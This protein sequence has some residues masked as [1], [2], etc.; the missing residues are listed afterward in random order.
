MLDKTRSS[1]SR[2]IKSMTDPIRM[3]TEHYVHGIFCEDVRLEVGHTT[4]IIGVYPANLAT[5]IGCPFAIPRFTAVLWV[6]YP[7]A[8]EPPS[9]S[10]KLEVPGAAPITVMENANIPNADLP[11]D[12]NRV[13]GMI[14]LRAANLVV[15]DLG[16]IRLRVQAWG[17]EWTA[18]S[19]RIVAAADGAHQ[20]TSAIATPPSVQSPPAAPETKR[21][22][23]RRPT[24]S[25]R[26]GRTPA[27]A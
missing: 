21:V 24:A 9:I 2:F 13:T 23:S 6:V 15:N 25:R 26:S 10:G 3:D 4:S 8:E 20:I 7:A 18:A 27:P 22:R 14:T 17:A 16:T 12:A 19:L 5:P 11:V 1:M